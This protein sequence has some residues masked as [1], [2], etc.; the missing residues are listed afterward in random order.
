MCECVYVSVC[1]CVYVRT[2]VCACVCVCLLM[3]VCVC[4]CVCVC[5][6]PNVMSERCTEQ[7]TISATQLHS[8]QHPSHT[9]TNVHD[10]QY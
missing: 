1:M 2:C 9:I 8:I 4:V 5:G 6:E 10:H 3:C 7:M